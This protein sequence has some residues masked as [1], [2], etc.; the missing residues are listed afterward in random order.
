MGGVIL[1]QH[2][3][4]NVQQAVNI[5]NKIHEA[6]HISIVCSNKHSMYT[7]TAWKQ[8]ETETRT[9]VRSAKYTTCNQPSSLSTNQSTSLSTNQPTK[10]RLFCAAS[11]R[12]SGHAACVF[13]CLK[14]ADSYAATHTKQTTQYQHSLHP[15]KLLMTMVQ[16]VSCVLYKQLHTFKSSDAHV[17]V[18]CAV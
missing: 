4:H 1:L 15:V 9:E 7:R 12:G 13:L 11:T 16:S 8:N 3:S 10:P 2:N 17:T 5:P 6:S 14:E 18:R